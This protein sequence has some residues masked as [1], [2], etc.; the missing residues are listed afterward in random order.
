MCCGSPWPTASIPMAAGIR[1]R[2]TNFVTR[3][4]AIMAAPTAR[5]RGRLVLGSYAY[6]PSAHLG[7]SVKEE[8]SDPPRLMLHVV[9]LA[10]LGKNRKVTMMVVLGSA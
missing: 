9:L 7:I 6:G 4:I 10:L 3:R 2:L 8:D 1:A 5:T